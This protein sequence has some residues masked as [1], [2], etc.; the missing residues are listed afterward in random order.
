MT[1]GVGVLLLAAIGG[2]WVLERASSHKGNLKRIGQLVGVAVIVISFVGIACR[3]W[4]A[5][6]CM[7]GMTGKGGWCPFSPKATVPSSSPIR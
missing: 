6:T 1:Y 3:V 4:Y 2:Y 5:A 7:P